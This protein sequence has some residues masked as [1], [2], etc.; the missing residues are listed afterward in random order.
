VLR[1]TPGSR[2]QPRPLWIGI[3]GIGDHDLRQPARLGMQHVGNHHRPAPIV[4]DAD[5]RAQHV[6]LAVARRIGDRE[7]RREVIG[8][9][10][11]ATTLVK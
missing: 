3:P 9:V 6:R 5:T 4:E 2:T 7:P 11:K 8:V 10:E 1:V